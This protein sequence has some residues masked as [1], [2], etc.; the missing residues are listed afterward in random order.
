M[1]SPCKE[2][3]GRYVGCHSKCADYGEYS[4]EV[5]RIREERFKSYVNAEYQSRQIQKAKDYRRKHRN[6]K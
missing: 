3:A 4:A 6:G 1:K 2:C 5:K